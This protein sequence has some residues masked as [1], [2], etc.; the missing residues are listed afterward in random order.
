ML[1]GSFIC[2]IRKYHKYNYYYSGICITCGKVR[3]EYKSLQTDQV[4][5]EEKQE[6]EDPL[7]KGEK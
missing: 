6:Q 3:N 7:L 5:Q 2:R 4:K 1:F